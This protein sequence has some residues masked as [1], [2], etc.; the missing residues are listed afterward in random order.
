MVVLSV[1]ARVGL[2]ILVYGEQTRYADVCRGRGSAVVSDGER[3]LLGLTNCSRGSREKRWKKFSS[4]GKSSVWDIVTI[5]QV[6][7][8]KNC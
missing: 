8:Q 1:G 6:Q 4:D 7:M 2:S 5:G 3:V